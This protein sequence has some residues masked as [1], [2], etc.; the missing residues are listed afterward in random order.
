VLRLLSCAGGTTR[1][2][3]TLS[4]FLVIGGGFRL[5]CPT[6]LLACR[7]PRLGIGI[8]LG[9]WRLS[10]LASFAP[11]SIGVGI[12]RGP[13]AFLLRSAGGAPL[14]TSSLLLLLPSCFGILLLPLSPLPSSLVLGHARFLSSLLSCLTLGTLG[15]PSRAAGLAFLVSIGHGHIPFVGITPLAL[16]GILVI[17]CGICAPALKGVGTFGSRGEEAGKHARK[18]FPGSRGG[19]LHPVGVG[20]DIR[21]NHDDVF[22]SRRPG[23]SPAS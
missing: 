7:P 11:A 5:P 20:R 12:V 8:L 1:L 3:T 21:V 23:M 4:R 13:S 18:P 9:R 10:F 19:S 22:L 2:A 16:P 15:S 17:G 14:C 6:A